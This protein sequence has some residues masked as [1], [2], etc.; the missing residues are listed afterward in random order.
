MEWRGEELDME[1]HK[2]VGY[3]DVQNWIMNC[4]GLAMKM[5]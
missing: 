3:G 5:Y 2:T 1:M 4:A